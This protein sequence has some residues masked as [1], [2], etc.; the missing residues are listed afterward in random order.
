MRRAKTKSL[1]FGSMGMDTNFRD[2]FLS[3]NSEI[4]KCAEAEKKAFSLH[5]SPGV[6]LGS[7]IGAGIAGKK[8]QNMSRDYQDRVRIMNT[9]P[10]QRRTAQAPTM[11]GGYYSQAANLAKNLRVVFTPVS[12]VYLVKNGTNDVAIETIDVEKMDNVMYQAWEHKDQDFFKRMLLN[13]MLMEVNLAEKMFAKKMV[14][15]QQILT[16]NIAERSGMKKTAS[17]DMDDDFCGYFDSILKMRAYYNDSQESQK[18]ASVLAKMTS[19]EEVEIV[20]GF[21]NE[22]EKYASLGKVKDVFGINA[23]TSKIRS[24][25]SRLESPTYLKRHMQIGFFPDRV[26]FVVDNTL[27]TSLSVFDM[28]SEGFKAFK[29]QDQKYFK[30]LFNKTIKTKPGMNKTA[31]EDSPKPKLLNIPRATAFRMNEIHPYVY[32]E[33]LKKKYGKSWNNCDLSALIKRIELDFKLE[34]TG[35]PDIPL[36]K[37]MSIYTCLSDETINAFISPLAFEKIA[38]SFNDL[39]IDFLTAESEGLGIGEIAFALECY[40]MIMADKGVDAY[41]LFSDEVI[42][43]IADVMLGKDIVVIYPDIKNPTDSY[44]QFYTELN[45]MILDKLVQKNNLDALENKESDAISAK[46]N[47]ILQPMAIQALTA[48]RSGK[49]QKKL[50]PEYIDSLCEENEFDMTKDA[51]L[52]RQIQLNLNTDDFLK[53]KR[54]AAK[55]QLELYR[56]A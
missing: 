11:Q 44:M 9:P 28:N 15:N 38:R 21:G 3:E 31:A 20:P 6:V 40:D 49:V 1:P 41:E 18:L 25:K 26:S 4:Q 5:V 22:P 36:N 29:E 33:I 2:S 10:P 45:R 8:G 17:F 24:L 51:L 48:I 43:Y 19:G 16:Q 54:G 55:T 53:A 23:S 46:Q 47:E 12:A 50:A 32:Y 42:A 37:V 35:I 7:L 13:K 56:L 52:R 34:K 14:A 27:I 30:K 39:P